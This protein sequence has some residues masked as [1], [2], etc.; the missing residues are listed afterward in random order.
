MIRSVHT[1]RGALILREANLA[2]AAQFRDL[3]LSGL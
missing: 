3:R 1:P 2:D